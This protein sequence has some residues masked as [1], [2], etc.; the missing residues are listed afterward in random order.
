VQS[1]RNIPGRLA[2]TLIP[3]LALCASFAV[4]AQGQAPAPTPPPAPINAGGSNTPLPDHG[5]LWGN[6]PD[7]GARTAAPPGAINNSCPY[8]LQLDGSGQC[9]PPVCSYPQYF[10][11]AAGGCVSPPPPPPPPAPVY[12][13]SYGPS[14]VAWVGVSWSTFEQCSV[15]TGVWFNCMCGT[16]YDLEPLACPS[17]T[18]TYDASRNRQLYDGG[19]TLVDSGW[20]A[21][22][23]PSVFDCG[24]VWPPVGAPPAPTPGVPIGGFCA[25]WG[26]W[27]TYDWQGVQS[28]TGVAC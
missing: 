8:P 14:C 9:V 22:S 23:P 18:G 11:N 27:I 16:W 2:P 12:Y 7:P 3:A 4:G 1:S 6:P 17:G 10:S 13:S 26:S 25:S 20:S 21:F 24:N 19:G 28:D 5:V 15:Y